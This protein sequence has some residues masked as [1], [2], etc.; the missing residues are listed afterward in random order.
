MTTDTPA[1]EPVE[2]QPGAS[3]LAGG[4]VLVVATGLAGGVVYAVPEVGY[5]VAGLLATTATRKARTWAT[6]RRQDTEEPQPVEDEL[7]VGEALRRLVGDDRGVL[8]TRLRNDLKLPDTRTLRNLLD[9]ADIPVRSGVRTSAGNGPGV[10]RDDIPPLE[11][12]HEP[13]CLCR[14]DANTNANNDPGEG[15]EKGLRVE[16]TGQ[17][18]TTV[19]DLAEHRHYPATR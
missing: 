6:S 2:E 17:A 4:C 12:A 7:D 1:Q 11:D 13:H 3:R 14:S 9:A 19:Y 18:G 16:H 15:S 10:H 5:F 8:L